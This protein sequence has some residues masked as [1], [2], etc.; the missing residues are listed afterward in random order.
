M[1]ELP[2]GTIL[3]N[4]GVAGS[5]VIEKL[6]VAGAAATA[7]ELS[8]V[9]ST[10]TFAAVLPPAIKANAPEEEKAIALAGALKG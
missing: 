9:L 5:P 6:P 8:Q 7:D 1:G 2:A 10:E 3:R 4:K